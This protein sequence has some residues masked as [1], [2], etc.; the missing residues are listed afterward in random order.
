M[1]L[2]GRPS[3][4]QVVRRVDRCDRMVI[5]GK[6][7]IIYFRCVLLITLRVQ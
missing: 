3:Y 7:Y 5:A 2:F 1:S 4:K 6:R